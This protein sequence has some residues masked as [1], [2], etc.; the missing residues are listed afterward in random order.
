MRYTSYEN[1]K[2]TAKSMGANAIVNFHFD[3]IP[4]N[5]GC[6]AEIT[7]MGNAVVLKPIKNYLPTSAIGNLFAEYSEI[8]EGAIIDKH[9]SIETPTFK[10][11]PVAEIINIGDTVYAVCPECG[12]KYNILHDENGKIKLHFEDVDK[13]EDGYQIYCSV[14]GAKFTIP[15]R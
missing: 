9:K 15:E 13:E 1:L 12:V 11:S 8:I 7:A 14:C 6:G 3:Y 5:T 4:A 2:N 10:K